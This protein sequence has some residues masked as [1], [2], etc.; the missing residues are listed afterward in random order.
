MI[1]WLKLLTTFKLPANYFK[2]DGS[3]KAEPS[4]QGTQ[5]LRLDENAAVIDTQ[6]Q[7]HPMLAAIMP[8]LVVSIVFACYVLLTGMNDLLFPRHTNEPPPG[9]EFYIVNLAIVLGG[10]YLLATCCW[11]VYI[12]VIQPSPSPLLLDRKAR[13][14]YGS[15]RGNRVEMDWNRVKPAITRGAMANRGGVMTL[16]NFNLAQFAEGQEPSNKTVECGMLLSAGNIGMEPCVALWEFIR[17]YMNEAPEKLPATDVLP[18]TG[19]WTHKWLERGP[20]GSI[21][22]GQPI[23]TLLRES[24]GVPRFDFWISVA[25]WF[26]APG[27]FFSLYDTWLRPQTRLKPEW[28]PAR[29]TDP[30][31]YAITVPDNSDR[32]LREKAA[33]LVIL[34]VATLMVSGCAFWW[35]IVSALVSA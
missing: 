6:Q 10:M 29:P 4:S 2:I 9:L 12:G 26:M 34:W 16:Y 24:N 14:V 32:P 22:L 35:W 17:T 3:V 28:I 33:K 27:M 1:K 7:A 25:A 19:D 31:P 18:D 5:V 20:Y 21:Y 11:L 8:W 13:K 23:T 30:N 15:Y